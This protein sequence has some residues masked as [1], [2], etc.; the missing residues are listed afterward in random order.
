M[1]HEKHSYK[2]RI[3]FETPEQLE[4]AAAASG[5]W[6]PELKEADI[7]S[8]PVIAT[9]PSSEASQHDKPEEPA[10]VLVDEVPVAEPDAVQHI[11]TEASV[12]GLEQQLVVL[13]RN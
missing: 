11:Q 2:P 6:Q 3:I 13:Q 10:L 8:E 1:I 7:H 5:V 12:N 4:E 9:A